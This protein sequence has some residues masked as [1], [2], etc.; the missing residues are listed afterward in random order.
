MNSNAEQSTL[1]LVIDQ[2][3][4]LVVTLIEEIRQRPGVAA[5][6]LAAIV[7]IV[8]GSLLAARFGRRSTSAPERV[9]RRARGMAEAGD[10]AALGIKLLQNPIVR[11]YVRNKIERQLKKRFAV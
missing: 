8:L 1:Q 10:L 7:G 2:V 5:A 6:I 11:S 4:E 3:E 9:V